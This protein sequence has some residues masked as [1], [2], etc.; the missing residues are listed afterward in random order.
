MIKS[1]LKVLPIWIKM[2]NIPM[3]AWSVEGI[4]ALA[5]S[6]GK[7]LVMDEMTIHMCQYGVGMTDYAKVSV[8]IKAKKDFG[9]KIK[10]EYIEKNENVKGTK[11]IDIYHHCSVFGHKHST[12]GSRV[13]NDMQ[14]FIDCVN[15]AKVEDLSGNGVFYTWIKSP[16]NPRNSVLKKLDRAMSCGSRFPHSFK[17]K[18]NAFR[19]ANFIA[20]KDEIL[21]TIAAG[22]KIDV[23]GHKMYKLVKKMKALKYNLKA[24]SWKNGV[25]GIKL[26]HEEA[27][28]MI[29]DVTDYEIKNDLIDIGDNKA[30]GPDGYTS[31]FFKK[32][33]KIVET[34]VKDID[35]ILKGFLWCKSEIKRGKSKVAWKIVCSPKSQGGLGLRP[36]GIWNEVLLIKNLWNIAAKKTLWV[37][38][39]NVVKLKG[40]AYGIFKKKYASKLCNNL[41]VSILRRIVLSTAV[42]N[43]WKERNARIITGEIKDDRIVVNV[44]IDNVKPQ[45]SCLKVKKS[46]NVDK[47]ASKWNFRINYK[48]ALGRVW[49]FI[50]GHFG[51]LT[52]KIYHKNGVTHYEGGRRMKLTGI[53]S[54]NGWEVAS[55]LNFLKMAL[56]ESKKDKDEARIHESLEEISANLADY[57]VKLSEASFKDR[58][59]FAIALSSASLIRLTSFERTDNEVLIEVATWRSFM[60]RLNRFMEI[61]KR[62]TSL[63]KSPVDDSKAV[64]VANAEQEM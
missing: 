20:E 18:K 4:S 48:L 46:C 55:L 21:P 49:E 39:V 8:K 33:C 34:V 5:C 16:L 1:E 25:F 2:I 38:W 12:G 26:N 53:F 35:R 27:M 45:L 54:G 36:F 60:A 47:V 40:E 51:L 37:K 41:I 63:N 32:S 61:S 19:F 56:L 11:E 42:Y 62:K 58:G 22:W 14:D 50:M 29:K 31:T 23:Q 24:L 30:P 3:E 7:P 43:I 28:D 59:F 44:I 13:T 9:N 10:I 17:K 57:I 15:E 6:L 52:R 64:E